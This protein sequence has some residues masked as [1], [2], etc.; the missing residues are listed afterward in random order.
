[1]IDEKKLIKELTDWIDE[2][3]PAERDIIVDIIALIE[4]QPKQDEWIPCSEKLPD[5]YES[6]LV[7]AEME[8]DSHPLTYQGA[9]TGCTFELSGVKNPED[10]IVTAWQPEPEPYEERER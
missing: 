3:F 5:L 6:V 2:A 1:M 7:T 8:G 9:R 4:N 10:Y